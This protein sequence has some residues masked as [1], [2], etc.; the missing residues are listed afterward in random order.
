MNRRIYSIVF[1]S[2]LLL[3]ARSVEATQAK[4]T[5]HANQ[6]RGVRKHGLALPA[7]QSVF[8]HRYDLYRSG[9]N[10]NEKQLN[11][12]SVASGFGKL[13]ELPVEGFV[14]AQ[15]LY[16]PD[17]ALA[18]GSKHQILVVATMG[19]FLYAFDADKA[20]RTG[21][22]APYLW[23]RRLT[24][25]H[26]PRLHEDERPITAFKGILSTPYIDTENQLIYVVA[27]DV[28]DGDDFAALHGGDTYGDAVYK[29][30][31]ISLSDG[32][33]QQSVK[34][35]GSLPGSGTDAKVIN[36]VSQIVFNPNQHLQR[37]ALLMHKGYLHLAFGSLG[38][39]QPFHGWIFSYRASD[40]H[41]GASFISSPA[42]LAGKPGAGIW[43]SGQG[44]TVDELGFVYLATGNG[45]FSEKD[46]DWGNSILKLDFSVIEEKFKTVDHFTPYNQK[47]LADLDLDVGS[48]GILFVPPH[49][50]IGA[51]KTGKFYILDRNSLGGY[52]PE[53][54]GDVGAIQVLQVTEP[55]WQ[56]VVNNT[57]MWNIHGS[58]VFWQ[59]QLFVMGES[60]PVKAFRMDISTGHVSEEPTSRST[61]STP[62]G[63]PGGFVTLSVNHDKPD[64]SAIVWVLHPL[65]GDATFQPRPGVLHALDAHDLTHELWNSQ[66]KRTDQY[67]YFAKFVPPVVANGRVYVATFSDKVVVYG[68]K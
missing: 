62:V 61:F 25:P 24:L 35:S 37:P 46:A 16:V 42:S 40:F 14:H 68:I 17:V 30:Y 29:L 33:I 31:K 11:Y 55:S 2:L 1:A 64:E 50:L 59:N 66:D 47:E 8:T 6:K 44:L 18:D 10:E 60:D 67:G 56:K 54:N 4:Q 63:M 65:E 34:V 53:K 51:G 19:N 43:Q 21:N 58:P 28:E 5:S 32:K 52:T 39:Q 3:A 9:V 41:G 36:G 15:P 45:E 20:P 22:A 7:G 26:K 23:R 38:D 13:F 48:A 57:F 27:M 12:Q 49:Y